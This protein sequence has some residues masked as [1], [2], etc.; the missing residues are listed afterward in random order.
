MG[1][2]VAYLAATQSAKFPLEQL[3]NVFCLAGPLEESPQLFNGD[4][5]LILKRITTSYKAHLWNEVLHLNFHG[6]ARDQL[7]D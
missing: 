7:V 3:A 6:A 4:L 2:L 5:S 1:T